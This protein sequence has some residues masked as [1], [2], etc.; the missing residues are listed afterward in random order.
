MYIKEFCKQIGVSCKTKPLELLLPE[1]NGLKPTR[2]DIP[3]L[4]QVQFSSDTSS[5][6]YALLKILSGVPPSFSRATENGYP[7]CM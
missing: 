1:E 5:R 3:F 7:F 2:L 6:H 4:Y